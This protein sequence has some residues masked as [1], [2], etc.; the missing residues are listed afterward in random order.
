[1]SKTIRLGTRGSKLALWQANATKDKLEQAGHTVEIKIIKTKG[2]QIQHLGF[3]K[4]EGKGFFTKEIEDSLLN[5]EIDFA[6]HSM[7]DLSTEMPEGLVITA[8]SERAAPNDLLIFKKEALGNN[9]IK[10]KADATIGTSSV[11][12]KVQLKDLLP[13]STTVDIRGNVPT[14]LQKLVDQA[15][16]DGIIL[17][18][19]G[20]DRLEID[21]SDFETF[22]FHT[23]EFV[24]APA[25]GVLAFQV[26]KEDLET[27]KILHVLHSRKTLE[28]VKV[29]RTILKNIG[30]GC[31]TPVGIYC[32]K[33]IRDVFHCH[34]AYAKDLDSP[35]QRARLSQSTHTHLAENILKQIKL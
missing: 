6:V 20:V 10:I 32:E 13:Q 15:D 7:K 22:S 3:D 33:D 1:M 5:N 26:R 28:T 8:I 19:A 11:R 27:R 30:G 21:L 24:P 16:L 29:E 35:I 25:Q 12:R 31:Q 9:I 4:M 17:A 14:R 23:S 18:K 2:D 34:L